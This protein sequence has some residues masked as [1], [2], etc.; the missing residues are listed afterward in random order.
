MR[1]ILFITAFA[2]FFVACN[3]NEDE[4]MR[5]TPTIIMEWDSDNH[6]TLPHPKSNYSYPYLNASEGDN[7]VFTTSYEAYISKIIFYSKEGEIFEYKFGSNDTELD[8]SIG[9]IK[10]IDSRTFNIEVY[11]IGENHKSMEIGVIP[12][13]KNVQAATF[14]IFFY[15]DIWSD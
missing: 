15:K 11:P 14:P 4:H 9:E 8:F 12:L 5:G 3:N 10:K 6:N 2:L 1:R 7:L 13:D